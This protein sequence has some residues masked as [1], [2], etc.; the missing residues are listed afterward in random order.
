M[1]NLLPS[2]EKEEILQ[3][4]NWKLIMI[5]GI[6]LSI[7]LIS[8]SLILFSIKIFV[9][10][11]VEAQKIIFEAREKEFKSPQMQGLQEGLVAFNK[12]LLQ[13]DSFYQNQLDLTEIL[14]EI[15]QTIPPEIYLNNLSIVPQRGEEKI[16]NC[17]LAGFSP[18]REIL[19]IFKEN[20]EKETEFHDI[21]FPSSCWV[22]TADINFTIRFKII[23]PR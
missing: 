22:K 12:N 19:L 9:S 13:L 1:I 6:L 7:F 21:Y 18:T 4:E 17:N 14:E 8:L 2:K 11:E 16:I 3:E 23:I 15:S 20:L 10:G 5:L